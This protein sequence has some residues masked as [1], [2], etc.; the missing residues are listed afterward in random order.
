[1]VFKTPSRQDISKTCIHEY[2]RYGKSFEGR[3]WDVGFTTGPVI[4]D[5][6]E[7]IQ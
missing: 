1:M 4:L 3:L 6:S 7:S 2:I 5:Y